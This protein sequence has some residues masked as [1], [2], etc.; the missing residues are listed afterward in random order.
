M[1]QI[2]TIYKFIPKYTLLTFDNKQNIIS[3]VKDKIDYHLKCCKSEV[4][5]IEVSLK[6]KFLLNYKRMTKY[7]L[8]K[9]IISENNRS[10]NCVKYLNPVEIENIVNTIFD[11]VVDCIDT[12]RDVAPE[13]LDDEFDSF[14][15]EIKQSSGQKTKEVIA[16][17]IKRKFKEY[18]D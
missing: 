13:D 7:I 1:Q 15:I 9:H 8:N 6:V 5:N 4:E 3:K 12:L 18:L 2:I 10:Y 11:N 17:E 14:Q 16:K